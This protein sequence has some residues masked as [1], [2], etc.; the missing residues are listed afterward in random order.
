MFVM[1]ERFR[2]SLVF[3]YLS[4][5]ASEASEASVIPSAVYSYLRSILTAGGRGVVVYLLDYDV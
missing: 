4:G 1:F 5:K 2:T 3:Q